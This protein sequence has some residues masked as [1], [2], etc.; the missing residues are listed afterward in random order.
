MLRKNLINRAALLRFDIHKQEVLAGRQTHFRRELLQNFTQTAFEIVAVSIFDAAVLHEE[1][2]KV[3]AVGLLLPAE[4][5]A[6]FGEVEW[7]RV[8]QHESRAHSTSPN[9]A[10]CSA[11]S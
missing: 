6:L 5:V 10:T 4:H 8:L 1:P 3:V 11:G 7:A 9:R 2:E